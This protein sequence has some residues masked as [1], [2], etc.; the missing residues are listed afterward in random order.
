MDK[1]FL[2]CTNVAA[3]GLDVPSVHWI[4]Q[5]D[6]CDDA[7]EY[8]HR[9]GRT[10]RGQNV[11]G[12]ALLFLLP[13]ELAYL[14]ELKKLKV[15]VR[16]FKFPIDKLANIQ[17]KLEQ[18]VQ[19]VYILYRNAREAYKSFIQAYAQQKK[20]TFDIYK[21]NLISVA[22]SFGFSAPPNVDLANV[23]LKGVSKNK[24]KIQYLSLKKTK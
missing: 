8:I 2:F 24:K 13:S 11:K 10:G 3:R 7:K 20:P 9:V 14:N 23:S 21:L 5:F 22:N 6:P 12:K 19:E 15:P 18:L 1:G 4:I 16:E 17:N